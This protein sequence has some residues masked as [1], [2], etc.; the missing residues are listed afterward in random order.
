MGAGAAITQVKARR[1]ELANWL[2]EAIFVAE[3]ATIHFR[4][5]TGDIRMER[6]AQDAAA[7]AKVKRDEILAQFDARQATNADEMHD[8]GMAKRV[9]VIAIIGAVVRAAA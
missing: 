6:K 7:Q 1:K 5:N 4:R 9:E 2:D 8:W 3:E